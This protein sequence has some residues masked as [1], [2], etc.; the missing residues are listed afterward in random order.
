MVLPKN[1]DLI[2]S[3]RIDGITYSLLCGF[4]ECT[5]R[6]E[7]KVIDGWIEDEGYRH[8]IEYGNM[9]HLCEE[10]SANRK[11]WKKPLVAYY[12]KLL[13][14]YPESAEAVTKTLQCVSLQFPL[15]VEFWKNDK[16]QRIRIPVL[17]EYAFSVR[18]PVFEDYVTLRGKFDEVFALPGKTGRK[19][20][21]QENKTKGKIDHQGIGDTLYAN[22]QTII[23]ST[24]LKLV[25]EDKPLAKKL[26]FLPGDKFGGFIYNVIRT[27]LSGM[28]PCGPRRK[29]GEE[30][31][32]YY[33]RV[34]KDITAKQKSDQYYFMRWK[35]ALQESDIKMCHER[36]LLPMLVQLLFWFD[37]KTGFKGVMPV[38]RLIDALSLQSPWGVYN[39]LANEWRGSFYDLLTKGSKFGLKKASTMFPELESA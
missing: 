14:E 1:H 21:L 9:W 4:R 16:E 7:K 8:A 20:W 33:R 38:S 2:W 31:R 24:A 37:S 19:I 25:M 11:D 35:V 28:P 17:Q 18:F 26:G 10:L 12:Q 23:Y 22:L 15:Y 34:A 13:G 32:A 6:F 29:A 27:P 30:D 36:T 5:A 39:S 3:P